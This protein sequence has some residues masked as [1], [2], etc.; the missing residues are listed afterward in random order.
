MSKLNLERRNSQKIYSSQRDVHPQ[1]L[2]IPVVYY[3]YPGSSKHPAVILSHLALWIICAPST[4]IHPQLSLTPWPLN[5]LL[6]ACT[7]HS[8]CISISWNRLRLFMFL[9]NWLLFSW[10]IF[11]ILNIRSE[12]S[13]NSEQIEGRKKAPTAQRNFNCELTISNLHMFSHAR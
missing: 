5:P 6:H 9:L 11:W 4:S 8:Y 3:S 13:S 10:Y 12:S 2:E 1:P 7:S